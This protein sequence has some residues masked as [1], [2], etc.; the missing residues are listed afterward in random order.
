MSIFFMEGKVLR[1]I[2]KGCFEVITFYST[3]VK[4][5]LQLVFRLLGISLHAYLCNIFP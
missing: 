5:L 4:I 1:K 2:T 3:P